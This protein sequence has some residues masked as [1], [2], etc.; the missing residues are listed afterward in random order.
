MTQHKYYSDKERIEVT[1]EGED[2]PVRFRRLYFLKS[3]I[4]ISCLT[5]FLIIFT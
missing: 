3:D 2:S 4:K 1:I 5:C